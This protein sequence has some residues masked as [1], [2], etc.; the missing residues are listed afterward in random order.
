MNT[1]GRRTRAPID[2]RKAVGAEIRKLRKSAG[3]TQ[4]ELADLIGVD[5]S[6]ISRWERGIEDIG[7]YQL[8]QVFDAL[9]VLPPMDVFMD[10]Y[11]RTEDA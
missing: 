8:L 10:I 1:T 2:F 5:H 11:Q 4:G 3:L 6:T 7:L 9:T